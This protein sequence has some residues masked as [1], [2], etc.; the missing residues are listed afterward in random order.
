MAVPEADVTCRGAVVPVASRRALAGIFLLLLG[1]AMSKP[2]RVSVLTRD[3]H[4][5]G[6]WVTSLVRALQERLSSASVQVVSVEHTDDCD[7]VLLPPGGA[8]EC[9][10]LVNRVSDAAPPATVKKTQAILALFELHGVPVING[11]KCFTLGTNKWL[12]HQVLQR[13]GCEVPG[14]IV[15]SNLDG[16]AERFRDAVKSAAGAL[17][18][19]GCSWPL[20]V[21]PNSGGFGEGIVSFS[22]V[23]ELVQWAGKQ[24][25]EG[26]TST[27]GTTLLQQLFM[28]RDNSIYRVWFVRGKICAAVSAVRPTAAAEGA[29]FQGGCVG[30]CSM[31]DRAAA[32]LPVFTAWDPPAEV[33]EKVL[34]AAEIAEADCG[35]IELLYDSQTGRAFYFDLNM[36]TTLPELSSPNPVRDPA[37]LWGPT[38]DFYAELADY[39]IARLPSHKRLP[40]LDSKI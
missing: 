35:S 17:I 30:A 24:C 37:N 28:P 7:A 40:H 15:V 21:K 25:A 23:E 19:G 27:D 9:D 14:S 10:L 36:V 33:R 8:P 6:T 12:H 20:L 11:A 31:K 18:D 13:A 1:G 34:K 29:L 2:L 38:Y 26:S 22:N 32:A 3:A 5:G 4:R 39:I 16:N